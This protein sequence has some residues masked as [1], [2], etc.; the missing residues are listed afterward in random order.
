MTVARKVATS[1]PGA[2]RRPNRTSSADSFN[3]AKTHFIPAI[4]GTP[5]MS[6]ETTTNGCTIPIPSS[7]ENGSCIQ[8][9]NK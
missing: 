6:L 9:A 5:T 2:S 4:S 1:V 8:T 7:S 3:P